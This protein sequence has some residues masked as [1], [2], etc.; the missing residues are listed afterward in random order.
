M[1][2]NLLILILCITPLTSAQEQILIPNL[3]GEIILDGI[4]NEPVWQDATSLIYTMQRPVFAAEPTENTEAFIFYDDEYLYF[5]GRLYDSEPNEI[6]STSK[7]RDSDNPN[8]QW[9]GIALDTYNDNE[10]AV[11]FFTTPSGLRWDAA[12]INDSQGNIDVENS[13]NTFWDVE[14]TINEQGWFAEFRIPLSSLRFQDSNGKVSMGLISWRS[15]PR[16][17]EYDIFPAIPPNWGGRSFYKI[18]EARDIVFNQLYSRNPLYVI[19]YISGGFQRNYH[20]NN[21]AIEYLR[22]DVNNIDLGLDLKYGLTSNMIMDITYNT[23][24]AQVEADDQQINLTRFSLFYPEKRPFFLER[25]NIFN[26]DFEPAEQNRL[27]YSRRIGINNGK[28]VPIYGGARL[29]GR[30]DSWDIGFLSMQA[31]PVDDLPSENFSVLRL[32]RQVINPNSYIGTISTY[33][34]R[35]DGQY[36]FAYGFDG[37]I[38]L[39]SD[40]FLTI[41]LAQTFENKNQNKVLSWNPGRV[42][43]N[44]QRQNDNG[45][46]YGLGYS[47]AGKDYNPGIGFEL[48]QN[49]QRYMCGLWYGFFHDEKSWLH[50]HEPVITASFYTRNID[51]AVES[52]SIN[53][54]WLFETKSGYYLEL[55]A[56]LLYENVP[57]EFLISKGVNIPEGKYHYKN[58]TTVFVTPSGQALNIDTK[59]SAGSFYDGQSYTFGVAPRWT[60]SS[61]FELSGKYE[62]SYVNFEKRSQ[63]FT[64]HIA[65][66]RLLYMLNTKF[67]VSSFIQYNSELNAVLTNLRLRYNPR[68]GV[69]LDIAYDETDEVNRYDR[70]PV[71]PFTSNRTII[72]KFS[73]VFD[74]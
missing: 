7:K 46:G 11:A 58:I 33:R 49:Y 31:E 64:G 70:V 28:L 27:F 72:L 43:L 23:D 69:A 12:I 38:N 13:W 8:C 25:S 37:V 67:S 62:I 19:P 48:R 66:L 26:F 71:I 60:I 14:V 22:N 24:F 4:S 45:L 74:L 61:S 56:L 41:R 50:H 32:R 44:F 10:N 51:G 73:H 63:E 39:W 57:T 35:T 65:Y 6:E 29:V 20:L 53:P 40:D 3:D 16:K 59:I 47:Y 15:I 55:N 54:K 2:I 1:S 5:A 42:R 52:A 18:S 36:N 34:K 17:N 68:E 9:F 21:E 30:A